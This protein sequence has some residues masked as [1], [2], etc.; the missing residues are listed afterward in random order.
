LISAAKT[1]ALI[2]AVGGAFP[3]IVGLWARKPRKALIG[4]SACLLA[5]AIGG[6]YA[7][8]P[9]SVGSL[10]GVIRAE[11][12]P[13]TAES[14]GDLVFKYSR[15]M[16][17]LTFIGLPVIALLSITLLGAALFAFM[18]LDG[19]LAVKLQA[20]FLGLLGVVFG[21]IAG[22]SAR[23][24]YALLSEFTVTDEGVTIRY[25]ASSQFLA[26]GSLLSARYRRAIVQIDLE[27]N[28]QARRVILSNVDLNP[29][30]ETVL[31][32]LALVERV[33]GHPVPRSIL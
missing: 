17:W 24:W 15:P 25:G 4:L 7:V 33:T 3:L 12:Q 28:G 1:G 5:G 8:I 20:V 6:T 19:G 10:L 18:R 9:V 14:T 23:N 30:R 32:A 11:K 31:K 21:W 22:L 26:W 13:S 16:V 2:G 27:F 29:Q